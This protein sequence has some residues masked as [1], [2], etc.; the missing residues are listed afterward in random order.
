[1]RATGA[2]PKTVT[3]FAT[4]CPTP[5]GYPSASRVG[6]K[7]ANITTF[8]DDGSVFRVFGCGSVG[9]HHNSYRICGMKGQIENL[10]GMGEKVM[11]RYNDWEK[12]EGMQEVCSSCLWTTR[13]N[14]R[15]R[16]SV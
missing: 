2:T 1:M 13:L 9:A 14:I 15:L 11:L 6:D 5:D 8:N 3:A 4:Y 16:V 12:P 10:R 7:T